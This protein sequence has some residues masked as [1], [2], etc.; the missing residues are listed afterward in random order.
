MKKLETNYSF[1]ASTGVI[2]LNDYTSILHDGLLVITNVTSNI[3]IYNF[4]DA[5]KGGV[6]TGNSINLTYDTSAMSDTDSLQIW[7]D[8]GL[9]VSTKEDDDRLNLI[10]RLLLQKA[11]ESP[12]WLDIVNN[13]LRT[14]VIGNVSVVGTLTGVTTVSTVTGVTT[15]STLSNQTNIGGYSADMVTTNLY[16]TDWALT[17]RKILNIV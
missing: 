15:V 6:V 5:T 17:T 14:N 7:Y 2:V 3:I 9:I 1:T 11:A 8:D 10:I 16:D 4:A 13:C 12:V